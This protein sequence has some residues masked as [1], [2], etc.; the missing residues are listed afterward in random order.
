MAI[1][2]NVRFLGTSP[3]DSEDPHPPGAGI[4]RF[5]EDVLRRRGFAVDPMDDWRD[6]GWVVGHGQGSNALD[7]ALAAIGEREW[8]LQVAPR[9]MPSLVARLL[10]RRPPDHS[11]AI[12]AIALAVDN[13]LQDLG[14]TGRS[15]RWDGPPRPSDP[16]TPP[17]AKA[18]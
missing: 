5:I 2:L 1:S 3:P 16:A 14:M 8:M 6:A 12:H 11:K 9:E 15:W 10:G 18:T 17:P 13:V 4:A 7:I